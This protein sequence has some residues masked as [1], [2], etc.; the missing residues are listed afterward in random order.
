MNWTI[1]SETLFFTDTTYLAVFPSNDLYSYQGN[2]EEKVLFDRCEGLSSH[3]VQI[4]QVNNRWINV[5]SFSLVLPFVMDEL[6]SAMD[7]KTAQGLLTKTAQFTDVDFLSIATIAAERYDIPRTRFIT[8]CDW[9]AEDSG[10]PELD[11]TWLP[12]LLVI[13]L[14]FFD[15]TLVFITT[16]DLFVALLQT[17]CEREDNYTLDSLVSPFINVYLNQDPVILINQLS[18]ADYTSIVQAIQQERGAL[19]SKMQMLR[20]LDFPE[21]NPG[22]VN[23]RPSVKNIEAMIIAAEKRHTISFFQTLFT[24][25][26]DIT[27]LSGSEEKYAAARLLHAYALLQ[28]SYRFASDGRKYIEGALNTLDL[29]IDLCETNEQ[30]TNLIYSKAICL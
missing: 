16:R 17:F 19:E 27:Q 6:Y 18:Q 4:D 29:G 22:A 8:T 12:D 26:I 15:A 21:Q 23:K 30:K 13:P 5:N 9:M 7:H 10:P 28:K 11:L 1:L 24:Y 20:D 3:F 25:E 2:S 14:S